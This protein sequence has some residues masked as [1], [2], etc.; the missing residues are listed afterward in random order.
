MLEVNGNKLKQNINIQLENHALSNDKVLMNIKNLNHIIK[1]WFNKFW[2]LG[3]S[4]FRCEGNI[5]FKFDWSLKRILM[6][7]IKA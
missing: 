2:K 4:E 5:G 1:T 7:S 6:T 3:I